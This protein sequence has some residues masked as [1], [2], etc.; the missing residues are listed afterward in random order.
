[1]RGR[2]RMTLAHFAVVAE[3]RTGFRWPLPPRMPSC[4]VIL[5][6]NTISPALFQ[7]HGRLVDPI[8]RSM[9]CPPDIA[10][11]N[12]SIASSPLCPQPV[13]PNPQRPPVS[14][15]TVSNSGRRFA[16]GRKPSRCNRWRST[17]FIERLCEMSRSRQL[18][19]FVYGRAR[20]CD[21]L[22]T[23]MADIVSRILR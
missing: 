20:C 17:Y 23:S 3:G 1:M 18:L 4:S 16:R 2:N 6:R 22:S 14:D 19:S 7:S 10:R 11:I 8:S 12:V 21:L 15:R 5:E 9:G 13:S